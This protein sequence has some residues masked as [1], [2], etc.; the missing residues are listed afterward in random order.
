MSFKLDNSMHEMYKTLFT[1]IAFS[2]ILPCGFIDST[3]EEIT[4]P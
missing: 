1:R 3:Y 4:K 2:E